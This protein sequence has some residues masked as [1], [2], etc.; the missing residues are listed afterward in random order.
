MRSLAPNNCQI[1]ASSANPGSLVPGLKSF[2]IKSL[3]H[4][5]AWSP[6]VTLQCS[7]PSH[8][9]N[10]IIFLTSLLEEIS[11]KLLMVSPAKTS[12]WSPGNF[13]SSENKS[14]SLTIHWNICHKGSSFPV[15]RFQVKR[16]QFDTICKAARYLD[17]KLALL[18]P[19]DARSTH[20]G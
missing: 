17:W 16:C 5:T 12:R 11:K 3:L 7:T 15:T 18:F 19:T 13:P 2:R 9:Q 6:T 14:I 20:E 10:R 1:C 4:N 8:P